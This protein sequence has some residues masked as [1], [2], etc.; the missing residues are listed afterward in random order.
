MWTFQVEYVWIYEY[1]N[2]RWQLWRFAL[3]QLKKSCCLSRDRRATR[4]TA[5]AWKCAVHG[6]ALSYPESTRAT[7]LTEDGPGLLFGGVAEQERCRKRRAEG[8][9]LFPCQIILSLEMSPSASCISYATPFAETLKY[10]CIS[11]QKFVNPQQPVLQ[12]EFEHLCRLTA[13]QRCCVF[14][15]ICLP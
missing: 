14:D 7:G 3:N 10:V 15:E 1:T 8:E 2:E 5:R 12:K 9:F 13:R 11:I 6:S 4:L